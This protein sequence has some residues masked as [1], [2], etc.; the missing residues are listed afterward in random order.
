MNE[1]PSELVGDLC[2]FAFMCGVAFFSIKAYFEALS[3]QSAGNMSDLFKLGYIESE[4]PHVHN[5]VYNI[6][7][8]IVNKNLSKLQLE[9][10]DTLVAIGYGKRAARKMVLDYFAHNSA[11]SVQEFI[12]QVMNKS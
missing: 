3:N 5:N 10:I 2:A 6:S 12:T 11:S 9:C 7:N 1:Q 4:Q 8:N